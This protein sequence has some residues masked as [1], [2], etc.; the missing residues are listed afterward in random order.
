MRCD[1][2]GQDTD[3]IIS[4]SLAICD[5]CNDE[6]NL[7]PK[8]YIKILIIASLSATVLGICLMEII[9]N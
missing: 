1:I 7:I 9:F 4:P 8:K 5:K 2:C 3:H 6:T